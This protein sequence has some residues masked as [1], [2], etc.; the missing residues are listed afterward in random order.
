MK[1][2]DIIQ[3]LHNNRLMRTPEQ[4]RAFDDAL[5]SL[6]EDQEPTSEY[7]RELF[8]V[9]DDA[10]EQKEVMWGLLHFIESFDDESFFRAFTDA[11]PGMVG[12]AAE[13]TEIFQARILNSDASRET[14][15]EILPTLNPASQAVIRQILN[16]IASS[17]LPP[18]ATH[19]SSA[20]SF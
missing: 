13:W 11:I 18:L 19:A 6:P 4:V 10:C 3:I 20:L 1:T 8:M 16:K 7:L 17:E 2:E 12:K 14:F 9:F 5:A 15:K